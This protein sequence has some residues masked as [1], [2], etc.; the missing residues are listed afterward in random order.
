MSQDLQRIAVIPPGGRFE[1]PRTSYVR[2]ERLS[3]LEDYPDLAGHRATVMSHVASPTK[4]GRTVQTD[5]ALS[6]FIIGR[7][8]DQ[9]AD[10]IFSP[11]EE[12]TIDTVGPGVPIQVL[13]SE[14]A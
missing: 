6:S 5:I 4:D 1:V 12:C 10:V 3:I 9:S 8:Y 13:Y 14:M 2:L 11:V 7:D